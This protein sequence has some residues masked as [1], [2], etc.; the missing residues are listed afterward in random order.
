MY[1][2]FLFLVIPISLV[3]AKI[4]AITSIKTKIDLILIK[5]KLIKVFNIWTKK[6]N[7]LQFKHSVFQQKHLKK[8]NCHHYSAEKPK[9]HQ[10]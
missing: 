7:D 2:C 10:G 6:E 4:F 3:W 8:G 1:I 5:T 9:K